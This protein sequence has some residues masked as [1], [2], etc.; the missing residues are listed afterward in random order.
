M[1]GWSSGG[2]SLRGIRGLGLSGPREQS[3]GGGSGYKIIIVLGGG[4]I[5][6]SGNG[7]WRFLWRLEKGE[8]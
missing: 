6:K 5:R 2:S 1:R 8:L 7:I 4:G 3:A